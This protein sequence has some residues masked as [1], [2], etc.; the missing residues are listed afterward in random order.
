[1]GASSSAA[2]AV[3]AA[4]A[5]LLATVAWA[6]TA[7]WMRHQLQVPTKPPP[8]L[9]RVTSDPSRRS[10]PMPRPMGPLPTRIVVLL[11]PSSPRS[12]TQQ[13]PRRRHTRSQLRQQHWH[14]WHRH[15]HRHRHRRHRPP[16][17]IRCP[18][19]RG[20]PACPKRRSWRPSA[21][22][23]RTRPASDRGP[24]S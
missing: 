4:H 16:P 7:S 14:P 3:A 1:M 20:S 6:S 10:T 23:R 17:Q 2:V 18:P 9:G 24:C 11:P 15:R 8:P 13:Q 19:R 22:S 5:V 21:R 12:P